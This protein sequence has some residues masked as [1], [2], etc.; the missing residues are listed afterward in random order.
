V[1]AR[2][3]QSNAY[4]GA[5]RFEPAQREY[6]RAL[7]LDPKL[8][9]AWFNMGVL[10]LDG[11]KPG[12]SAADRLEKSIAYFDRFAAQGGSDPKLAQY[13]KDA[14]SALDR[15]KRRLA[16]DEKDRLRKEADVKKKGEGAASP[17]PAAGKPAPSQ[18]GANAP[19]GGTRGDK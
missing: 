15:E 4:R 6:E 13:R 12:M 16:R 18:G 10:Y 3:N 14:A 9:D 5:R 2:I 7:M 17:A 1:A 19:A 11:E 8:P